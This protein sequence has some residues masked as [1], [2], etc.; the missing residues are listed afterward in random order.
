MAKTKLS[1]TVDTAVVRA[2]SRASGK[3]SRSEIVELALVRWLRDRKK[4][5]LEDDIERYYKEMPA[6]E[7]AE[8]GEWAEASYQSIGKTWR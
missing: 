1:V 4:Q 6:E 7:R 2:L 8:D 3:A 5:Q